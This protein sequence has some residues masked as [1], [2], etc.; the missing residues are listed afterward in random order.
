MS[1]TIIKNVV[2]DIKHE[3]LIKPF[4]TA[5]HEVDEVQA[6]R[7]K[8]ILENGLVGV[9]TATPNEKVTGDTL[10]STFTIMQ[11]TIAPALIGKDVGDWNDLLVYLHNIIL[12]NTPS[13]AAYEIALYDLR[14]QIMNVSLS[15]LLGSSDCEPVSTDYT[16]SIGTE[17]QMMADAR[18]KVDQGFD[19]IKIKLGGHALGEDIKLISN[20]AKELG[21]EVS[22]RLDINQGW[23]V[24]Q[25]LKAIEVWSEENLNIAFVEQ[26][27]NRL[28]TY[29][30]KLI[31]SH[32]PIDI[33]ADESVFDFSDALRMINEHACDLINIKLMKTGGL[34]EAEKINSLAESAGVKCMIGCM[35]ES[36]ESIT[37]AV[38]FASSHKNVIYTDLDSVYMSGD[39]SSNGFTIEK[40]RLVPSNN[41]GLGF[42]K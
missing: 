18:E 29:G 16:I 33:M 36:R 32:S 41:M 17:K 15:N 10:D 5:L 26:P 25:T 9:G 30:M 7:V 20:I 27:V 3:P 1:S 23:N 2:C 28:D 19:S 11:D 39:K 31:A 22:L 35:I 38:D 34:S 4:V 8:I 21:N 14:S 42:G 37:A 40:N 13:K 6:V 12:H 24:K